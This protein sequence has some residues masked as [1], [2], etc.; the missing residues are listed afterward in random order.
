MECN[1]YHYS[2]CFYFTNILHCLSSLA[3]NDHNRE[4]GDILVFCL[5]MLFDCLKKNRVHQTAR[6]WF[7]IC[8][9]LISRA[10]LLVRVAAQLIEYRCTWNQ[11]NSLRLVFETCIYLRLILVTT[12]LT[13]LWANSGT[14]NKSRRW[15]SGVNLV[16]GGLLTY[17]NYR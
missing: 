16:F 11:W 8:F 4:Y 12:K 13:G 10:S 2:C 14:S 17:N 1:S 9:S 6:K 7:F 15:D 3:D 5:V